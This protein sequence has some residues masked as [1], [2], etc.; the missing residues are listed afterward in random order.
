MSYYVV[1]EYFAGPF[2]GIRTATDFDT[3]FEFR[4]YMQERGLSTTEA[5]I[6]YGITEQ[7]ALNLVRSQSIAAAHLLPQMREFVART[8]PN[9]ADLLRVLNSEDPAQRARVRDSLRHLTSIKETISAL[10]RELEQSKVE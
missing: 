5:V 7:Q 8:E 2:E 10:E 3:E 4:K 6:E 1:F 9:K